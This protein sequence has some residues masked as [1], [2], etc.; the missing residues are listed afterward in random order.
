MEGPDA[1]PPSP[2]IQNGWKR[3]HKARLGQSGV[4][5]MTLTLSEQ[6]KDGDWWRLCLVSRGMVHH[7][8]GVSL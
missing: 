3:R 4:Y 1:F 7:P 6:P 8:D 2:L 5:A